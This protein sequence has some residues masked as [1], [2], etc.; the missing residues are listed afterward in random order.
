METFDHD[1]VMETTEEV[2]IKS[3][4]EM[5][6]SGKANINLKVKKEMHIKKIS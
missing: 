5:T 4:A 3:E 2:F 1:N 6:N